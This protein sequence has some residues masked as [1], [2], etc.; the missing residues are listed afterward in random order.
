MHTS[1]FTYII[2]QHIRLQ[3]HIADMG[4]TSRR[5]AEDLIRAGKILVNGKIV[6]ELG[7]KINPDI[8]NVSLKNK[9]KEINKNPIEQ[10]GFIY[11][12][13]N[14]PVGYICSN[15]SSQGASIL[16]LIIKENNI[17]RN[18]QAN[19][20]RVYPVGRLDKDSEGLVLLTNDG[21]LTNILTH[22]RYE[23]TKEYDVTV[24]KPL[25]KDA[26]HI[27]E[28]GMIL[29]DKKL[30]GITI[31]KEFNKGKRTIIT[32]ILEEGKNRQLRKMFG[33]I[34]YTITTLRRTR[35]G[36][37]RLSTLPVGT[38]KYVKKEHIV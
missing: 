6:T 30:K 37:L 15:T 19:T 21:E 34:G 25:T 36:R 14:K 10:H 33:R 23:H 7:T 27:L 12:A 18:K 16:E 13:L 22:P 35:I 9:K 24:D 3:K 31:K 28:S 38:W 20:I 17:G 1:C 4:I 5:K 29:N 32:L 2:M 26:R 8:D 11:I